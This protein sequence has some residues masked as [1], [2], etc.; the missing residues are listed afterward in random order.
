MAGRGRRNA[1]ELLALAVASGQTLRDAAAAA[2]VSERT[3]ARRRADPE[4]LRRVNDLR[5]DMTRCALGRLADSMGEAAG[6]LRELLSAEAD[7]VKLG[8]ARS[9]LQL[10]AELRAAVEM[11]ER[12]RAL[13]QALADAP[14]GP[15]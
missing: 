9:I 2:G 6:K 8:A 10:G 13:E 14:E 4:F 5:A 1:D 3:A 7:S 12:L 11:E 15:T